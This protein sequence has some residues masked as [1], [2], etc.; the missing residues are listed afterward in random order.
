MPE[1]F[2]Y[3]SGQAQKDKSLNEKDKNIMF[4]YE[5]HFDLSTLF[6]LDALRG[7]RTFLI[8]KSDF[9]KLF[10]TQNIYFFCSQVAL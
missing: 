10:D 5:V 4:A 1:D 8:L 6:E 7:K 9:D 2:P 3:P